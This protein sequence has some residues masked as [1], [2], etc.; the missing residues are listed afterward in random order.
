MQHKNNAILISDN[1][2]TQTTIHVTSNQRE[3]NIQCSTTGWGE[4]CYATF[5]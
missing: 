1:D 5:M 2:I 4:L 3:G